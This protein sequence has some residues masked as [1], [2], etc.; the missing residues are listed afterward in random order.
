MNSRRGL[1]V[2]RRTQS[3]Q[4]GSEKMDAGQS[5]DESAFLVALWK[6][7]TNIRPQ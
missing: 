4:G 3:A 6:F 7:R 1:A 5:R 2:Q